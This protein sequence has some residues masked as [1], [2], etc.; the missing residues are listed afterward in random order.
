MRVNAYRAVNHSLQYLSVLCLWKI[1]IPD[2]SYI[3]QA[4]VSLRKILKIS[5]FNGL[6]LSEVLG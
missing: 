5:D 1:D 2:F 6:L 3:D 4:C